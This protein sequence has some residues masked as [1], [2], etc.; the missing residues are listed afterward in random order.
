[1]VR[2]KASRPRTSAY[3][4]RE[5]PEL[6]KVVKG[7]KSLVKQIVPGAEQTRNAWGVPTFVADQ[8]F[9][10]YMV[11]KNHVTFGFHQGTSLDDPDELLEGTGKNIR[12]V[13]LKNLPDLASQ[14]LRRLV[15]QA[16]KLKSKSLLKG[17]GGRGKK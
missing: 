15:D 9:C 10:F 14:G 8:P 4:K 11:G 12:H 3:V 1:V 13:K 6:R 5:N 2:K 16:S 7:L 17:M